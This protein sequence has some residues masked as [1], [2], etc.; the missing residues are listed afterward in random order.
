MSAGVVVFTLIS[1]VAVVVCCVE[2]TKNDCRG[3]DQLE[4]NVESSETT[5]KQEGD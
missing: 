1:L 5:A 3:Q 4:E 2:H